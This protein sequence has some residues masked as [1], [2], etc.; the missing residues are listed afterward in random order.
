LKISVFSNCHLKNIF[1]DQ[2]GDKDMKLRKLS[3]D[4]F[5][6]EFKEVTV[7]SRPRRFCFVLG[8]GAS[9]AGDSATEEVG[10][11]A[12]GAG[13]CRRAGCVAAATSAA[14]SAGA[15][16]GASTVRSVTAPAGSP[17]W[18]IND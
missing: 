2:N 9:V 1:R 14:F 4:G 17:A 10:A 5:I 13:P 6:D 16:A 15:A 7:S 3:L 18:A 11:A 8:A 12:R